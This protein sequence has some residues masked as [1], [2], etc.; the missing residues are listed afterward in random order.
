MKSTIELP[1]DLKHRLDILAERS[2][3]TPSRII[4]DAL[5]HGRSL[6]WQEKWTSGVRAGLAEADAGEF[7]TAEEIGVVLSKYAKA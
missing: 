7:V 3:S 4:E 1:D 6:A 2:N 5:S